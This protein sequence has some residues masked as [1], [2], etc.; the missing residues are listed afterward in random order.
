MAI[1]TSSELKVSVDD[2]FNMLE[3]AR[4]YFEIAA[5][6]LGLDESMRQVLQ[7][8]ERELMVNI[9][10]KMD[11]GTIKLFN[12]YR[13]QHCSALGPYKGGLRYHPQVS[14]GEV[15]ALAALMTWKCSVA[16]IPY[17]GGKGGITCDPATM[18]DNELEKVTRRF[19]RAMRPII[20]PRVDI[21]APDVNTNATTMAWIVDEASMLDGQ[22]VPEIVTGKPILMGGSLGRREAT[23]YGVARAV[24]ETLDYLS[25]G[26]D[27]VTVAIQGFGNVGSWA[28][29]R[30]FRH[31]CKIVAISDV[32]GGYYNPNGFDVPDVMKYQETSPRGLLKGYPG[33]CE[34][35]S[36]EELLTLDVTVFIPAALENQIHSGNAHE[37][38]ARIIAEGA[39]GPT[40]LPADQVLNDRGVIVIPDILANSGGVIVSYFEW[41]Q[42][43]HGFSWDFDDVIAKLDNKMVTNLHNVW[44]LSQEMKISLREAAFLIAIRRVVQALKLRNSCFAGV[45]I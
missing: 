25:I 40:T 2:E 4:A 9:P 8:P 17:G 19:V 31:G 28:A 15:R 42:N 13:V 44:E 20:G 35:I 7:H 10:V 43:L 5:D 32:T 16:D 18:S 21:P 27:E 30:L 36:N 38:K 6:R 22:E 34:K 37:V 3:N 24:L 39:N 11:D 1:E 26:T 41:V 29:E 33:P 23:G 12:G 45:E 14:M